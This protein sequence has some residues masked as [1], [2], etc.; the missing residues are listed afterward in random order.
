MMSKKL[1]IAT[2]IT[3]PLILS[4]CANN[5]VDVKKGSE[6]V[7]VVDK[8]KVANCVDKGKVTV[9]VTTKV[10]LYTRSVETV[11]A[12]LTQLAKNSA[13]TERADTVVSGESVNFGERIF[14]IYQCR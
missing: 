6:T 12:D 4:A 3:L 7:A 10:G 14:G 2:A 8:S 11:E 5:F 13:L 1:I 9:S